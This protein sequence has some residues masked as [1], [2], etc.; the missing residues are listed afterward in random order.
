M[1]MKTEDDYYDEVGKR[2][3]VGITEDILV[4]IDEGLKLYPESSKLIHSKGIYLAFFDRK[5][6]A[7]KAFEKAAEIDPSDLNYLS[8]GEVLGELGRY[9]E[10]I[11]AFDKALEFHFS[12]QTIN[13]SSRLSPEGKRRTIHRL[14]VAPIV[15]ASYF[16]KAKALSALGCFEQALQVVSQILELEPEYTDFYRFG[17]A[18][19]LKGD[20]LEKTGKKEEAAVAY[21]AGLKEYDR[22][23]EISPD[24][25]VPYYEKGEALKK[26]GRHEEAMEYFRRAQAILPGWDIPEIDEDPPKSKS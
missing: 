22:V 1:K 9:A 20:I 14:R 13:F 26:L 7:L 10:A 25:A 24:E 5:E 11:A 21:E 6:E 17:D 3:E 19:F 23:I 15:A 4:F 8:K 2:G 18:Y 12:V 16:R